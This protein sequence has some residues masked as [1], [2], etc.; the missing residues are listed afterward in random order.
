MISDLPDYRERKSSLEFELTSLTGKL[1]MPGYEERAAEIKQA[2]ADHDTKKEMPDYEQRRTALLDALAEEKAAAAREADEKA[3][4]R[5][6]I[7]AKRREVQAYIREQ[8]AIV[9]D[10][11][12]I[13]GQKM[14][15]EYTRKRIQELR[16]AQKAAGAEL[17]Q[18]AAALYAMEAFIRWKTRFVEGSINDLFRIVTFRL[19]REQANG[20]LEERCDV[21]VDGVPYNALNNGTRINAGLDIIRRLAEH[22]GVRVPLFVDNAEGV[23]RLEDAGTQVIRL[24]V[25]AEDKRL[26]VEV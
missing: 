25:S 8:E 17:E 19:F 22:Y 1:T 24:V 2:F 4:R 21:V 9:E 26:R 12:R 20:G 7:E 11:G 23:T 10:T 3:L 18:V 6:E 14:I 5:K 15:L 13:L 16:E